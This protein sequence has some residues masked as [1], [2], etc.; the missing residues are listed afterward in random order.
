[1]QSLPSPFVVQSPELR[2]CLLEEQRWS[3]AVLWPL[4]FIEC[5]MQTNT[6]IATIV[7]VVLSGLSRAWRLRNGWTDW[8][9]VWGGVS[10]GLGNIVDSTR[11]LPDYFG[12]VLSIVQMSDIIPHSTVTSY[13]EFS[14]CIQWLW[15][16]R[17]G[18][19]CGR[20][21]Q[22]VDPVSDLVGCDW[23]L[24]LVLYWPSSQ[25]AGE[26][27]FVGSSE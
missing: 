19:P 17:T 5:E 27:W 23:L 9:A 14:P 15:I 26:Q 10:L 3:F 16:R 13:A 20:E 7:P 18:W 8:G 1:M 21:H 11:P 6:K 12:Y 22:P 25:P 2:C 4:G 24:C